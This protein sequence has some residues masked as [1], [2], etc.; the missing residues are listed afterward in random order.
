[1]KEI[2]S[3]EM[4]NDHY[5]NGAGIEVESSIMLNNE[6]IAVVFYEIVRNRLQH[7]NSWT[8]IAPG[9]GINFQL[10][11]RSGIE[12]YRKAQE[13]DLVRMVDMAHNS[14]RNGKIDWVRIDSLESSAGDSADNFAFNVQPST[15][16]VSNKFWG[17]Q[18]QAL[19]RATGGFS[20]SRVHAKVT[21]SVC[22]HESNV[23]VNSEHVFDRQATVPF[24][25][26]FLLFNNLSWQA[27]TDGLISR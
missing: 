26:P 11:N 27:L 20:V 8:I 12:V 5:P 23:K 6:K 4:A 18:P 1:M 9:L 2:K 17:E 7:V 15:N 13:G 24:S 22:L 25:S 14:N 3:N 10:V 21:A 19:I 16:P